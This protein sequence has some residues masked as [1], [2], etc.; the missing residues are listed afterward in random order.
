[1]STLLSENVGMSEEEVNHWGQRMEYDMQIPRV[2]CIVDFNQNLEEEKVRSTLEKYIDDI[3]RSKKHSKQDISVN[4]AGGYILV[5]K[6]LDATE[7]WNIEKTLNA[8]FQSILEAMDS[9]ITKNS[10]LYVGLYHQGIKGY[11]ESYDDA[12]LLFK[13]IFF[14]KTKGVIF[15]HRNLIHGIYQKLGNENCEN[16]LQPYIDKIKV[17]FGKGTEDAIL[18]M[19]KLLENGFQY[20]KAAKE[21]YLHKNTVIF[22]KK[23]M[24]ECLGLDPKNNS[25]DLLLMKLI[26]YDN[27]K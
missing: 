26:I 13:S 11:R 6:K 16:I 17:T 20:E 7:P 1:V 24:D 27:L 23:K 9:K 14:K 8:Y 3:K 10:H 15:S 19:E 18:T 4:M 22:R 12:V 21:L 25:D 5:F 2:A